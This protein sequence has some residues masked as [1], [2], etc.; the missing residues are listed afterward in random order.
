MPYL[1]DFPYI[2]HPHSG[3]DTGPLQGDI[4]DNGVDDN[5]PTG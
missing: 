1:S 2:P 3:Y 5:G 4:P